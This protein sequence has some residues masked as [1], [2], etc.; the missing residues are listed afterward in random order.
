MS[1]RNVDFFAVFFIAVAMLA[2]GNLASFGR[3][4]AVDAIRLQNA[5]NSNNCVLGRI[6]DFLNQ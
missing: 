2:F 1:S 6:A 5:A 4:H 3:S